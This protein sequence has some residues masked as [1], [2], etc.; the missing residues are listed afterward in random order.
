MKEIKAK[1]EL[2]LTYIEAIAIAE[3]LETLEG[4]SGAIDEKFTNEA[5]LAGK[6]AKRIRKT[7]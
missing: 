5:K 7:I 4:M 2:V 3:L 1:K 6:M